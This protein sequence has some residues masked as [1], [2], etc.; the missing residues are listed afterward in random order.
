[1]Y[2]HKLKKRAFM[3]SYTVY[4]ADGGK[5]PLPTEIFSLR[6]FFFHVYPKTK[7]PLLSLVLKKVDNV[8][9]AY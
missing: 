1:M 8:V 3:C 2:I 4:V 7:T 6:G 5:N 9:L